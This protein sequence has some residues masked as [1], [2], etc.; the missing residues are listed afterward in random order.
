MTELSQYKHIDKVDSYFKRDDKK[1]TITFV[2]KSLQ[3]HIPKN[4][5]TYRLLEITDCVKAL[6]V[7]GFYAQSSVVRPKPQSLLFGLENQQE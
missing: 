7:V 3:V 4:F 2:G 1:R 6:A 5:E